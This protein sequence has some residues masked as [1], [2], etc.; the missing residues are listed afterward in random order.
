MQ[1][2][3]LLVLLAFPPPAT[4]A[5]IIAGFDRTGVE[6]AADRWVPRS[7]SALYGNLIGANIGPH[8]FIGTVDK[9]LELG[10]AVCFAELGFTQILAQNHLFA[11]QARHAVLPAKARRKG[12]TLRMPQQALRL[13][14]LS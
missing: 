9:R 8:V 3:F 1:S 2:I 11:T 7:G 14:T 12:S 4:D 6:L 5:C 13:S 10:E